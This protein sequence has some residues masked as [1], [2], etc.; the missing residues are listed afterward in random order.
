MNAS[1]P[2][3]PGS[4][5]SDPAFTLAHRVLEPAPARPALLLVLLHGVGGNEGNLGALGA[6][7]DADTLVVLPRGPITLGPMQFGWFQVAFSPDGPKIDA[8]QAEASRQGLVRFLG[9]LQAAY[10]IAPARTTIAGFS[11][12]GILSASVA[13]TTPGCV[14]GFAVL[15]GRIL[16]EIEPRLAGREALATLRGYVAHGLHDD[17][18]PVAWARRADAWL[19][20]LGVAHV[21]RLHAGGHALDP[22]MRAGFLAWLAAWGEER[23][24]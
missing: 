11:Q 15:A 12:G 3:M 9:E 10:G 17:K 2:R 7:V 14:G 8:A 22:E 5:R 19:E 4:L 13:L 6:D 18:L 24:R 1:P 21:T 20:A 23:A 16:P